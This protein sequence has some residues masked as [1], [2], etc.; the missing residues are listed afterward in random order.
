MTKHQVA[1]P[2]LGKLYEVA[3][4]TKT[5]VITHLED[6]SLYKASEENVLLIMQPAEVFFMDNHKPFH[7]HANSFYRHAL[8][9]LV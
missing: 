7:F 4:V 1:L 5:L 3:L 6:L 8:S 9:L 2:L